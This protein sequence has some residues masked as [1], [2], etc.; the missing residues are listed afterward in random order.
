MPKLRSRTDG[1]KSQLSDPASADCSARP[2][3][4]QGSPVPTTDDQSADRPAPLEFRHASIGTS[5]F[6]TI[7]SSSRLL[8]LVLPRGGDSARIEWAA[9]KRRARSPLGGSVV[10][11]AEPPYVSSKP[12]SGQV[13]VADNPGV[14][15]L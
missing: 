11:N 8:L 2:S 4:S 5:S 9:T 3:G 13:P 1:R 15:A 10:S 7:V 14:I 12:V 6:N